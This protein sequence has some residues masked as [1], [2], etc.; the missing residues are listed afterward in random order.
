MRSFPTAALSSLLL[1]GWL[2]G[3]GGCDG[4]RQN[5][6]T[7][8]GGRDVPIEVQVPGEGSRPREAITPSEGSGE[9]GVNI[10]A[11]GVQ[12]EIE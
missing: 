1:V 2:C 11:G 12:V 4:T 8:V 10:D 9:R 6:V 5:T 3:C 7:P